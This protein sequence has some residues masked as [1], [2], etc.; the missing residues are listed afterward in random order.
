MSELLE[1][2]IDDGTVDVPIRNRQGEQI[3]MFTF[4]PGDLG[5][6]NRYCE[7]EKRFPEIVEPL[8]NIKMNADGTASD[9]GDFE[10]LSE[11]AEKIKEETDYMLGGNFSESFFGRMHPLSIVGG[12]FY[13]MTALEA[14]GKFIAANSGIER[15]GK[16]LSSNVLQYTGNYTKKRKGKRKKGG[17]S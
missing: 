14:V 12:K 6:Y 1:I 3:G 10:I 4:R 11:A 8:K 5:I 9:D 17:R 7:V 16:E 2:V 13:F 15:K